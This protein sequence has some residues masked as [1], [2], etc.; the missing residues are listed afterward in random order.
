VDG[1]IIS[2]DSAQALTGYSVG[3]HHMYTGNWD[4]AGY[5]ETPARCR[6]RLSCSL[7]QERPSMP[8]VP[9]DTSGRAVSAKMLLYKGVGSMQLSSG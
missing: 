2:S 6:S 5:R 7:E 3:L 1:S 9:A 8:L 4:G